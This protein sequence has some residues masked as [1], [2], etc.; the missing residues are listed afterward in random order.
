MGCESVNCKKIREW[1]FLYV[2]HE[3]REEM[4]LAFRQHL[5]QCPHCAQTKLHTE[6]L[7][8]IVRKRATRQRAPGD[9]RKKILAG[10][11]HRR[12]IPVR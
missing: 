3:M 2:D 11:P 4:V 6:T 8:A 1:V 7:L 5:S 12:T 9:L 10:L